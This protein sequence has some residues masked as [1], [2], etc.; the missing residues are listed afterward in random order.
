[1]KRSPFAKLFSLFLLFAVTVAR[2]QNTAEA[3]YGLGS[4]QAPVLQVGVQYQATRANAPPGQCGCFWM[5]GGGVQANL[6]VRPNWSAM[7]DVYYGSNSKVNGTDEQLSIFNY[8]LGPRYSYRTTTRYTPYAQV[9]AGASHVSS[10][11]VVYSSNNTFLA[12]QLGAGVEANLTPHISAVPLEADWVYSRAVNGVNTRQ[13]NL[14]VGVG[15]V[16]RF[17][18]E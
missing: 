4:G 9:L 15:V 14:R 8:V 11:Y 5:E 7:F 1:M 17:G 2:A 12:A 16:Y 13:N 6:S 10:N 3:P 18:P